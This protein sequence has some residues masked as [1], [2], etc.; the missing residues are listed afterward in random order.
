MA[1]LRRFDKFNLKYYP[2]GQSRLREIFIKQ[3]REEQAGGGDG[4]RKDVK[5][6]KLFIFCC[7]QVKPHH[8][9]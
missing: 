5:R 9:A 4:V 3:V 7:C 2:F 8:C 6:D 1:F